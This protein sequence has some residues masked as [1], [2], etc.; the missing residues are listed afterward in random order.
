MNSELD[1]Q[2][3]DWLYFFLFLFI[4]KKL[5]YENKNKIYVQSCQA[6]NKAHLSKWS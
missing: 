6:N 1:K 2:Y 3:D 4:L 5:N